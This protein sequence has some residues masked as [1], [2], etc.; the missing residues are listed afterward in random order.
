[1][2]Q[3]LLDFSF[4]L[5]SKK[6]NS[7]NWPCGN[8]LQVAQGACEGQVRMVN[9]H[10]TGSCYLLESSHQ[11]PSLVIQPL[12]SNSVRFGNTTI[13]KPS[14]HLSTNIAAFLLPAIFFRLTSLSVTVFL[15][16]MYNIVSNAWQT[17]G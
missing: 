6:N 3:T 2:K 13:G 9:F 7:Q 14:A 16:S 17:D 12:P 1:M 5:L 4:S 10:K 15:G 8:P 11:T